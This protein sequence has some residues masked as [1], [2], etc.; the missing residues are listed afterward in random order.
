ML[1]L[2]KCNSDLFHWNDKS[3]SKQTLKVTPEFCI[4]AIRS[5]SFNTLPGDWP[6]GTHSVVQKSSDYW[7]SPNSFEYNCIFGRTITKYYHQLIIQ[8]YHAQLV[9]DQPQIQQHV[10]GNECWKTLYPKIPDHTE[11]YGSCT[12]KERNMGYKILVW[13]DPHHDA[14]EIHSLGEYEYHQSDSYILIPDLHIGGAIQNQY[15]NGII[16]LDNGITLIPTGKK[17]YHINHYLR[18]I[19]TKYAR[20]VGT[21]AIAPILEA[22]IVR[23]ILLEK[24]RIAQEW[25]RGCFLQQ[26]IT[27]LQHWIITTFPS[28]ASRW[29][30]PEAGVIIHPVGDALQ[31]HQCLKVSQY[32]IIL[33]RKIN[34]TCY[35]DFPIQRSGT[36]ETRFLRLSD[37]QMVHL[38]PKINCS[39]R[40]QHTFIRDVHGEFY[41]V[42]SNGSYSLVTPEKTTPFQTTHFTLKPIRGYDYRTI[43]QPPKILE[44]YTALSLFSTMHDALQELKKLQNTHGNGNVLVGIGKALGLAIEGAAKG[45]S[46]VIKAVGSAI[47]DTLDG[48]GDLDEKIVSSLGDAASNVIS[49]TGNAIKDVG[50]GFGS[51]F[52]GFFG[53]IAGLIKWGAILLIML[54]LVYMN[55]GALMRCV[56]RIRRRKEL[57]TTPLTSSPKHSESATSLKETSDPKVDSTTTIAHPTVVTFYPDR[58]HSISTDIQEIKQPIDGKEDGNQNTSKV[59]TIDKLQTDSNK[60]Q[61][62]LRCTAQVTYG[63]NTIQ[64]PAIID[65]GSTSTIIRQDQ[66]HTL[67]S[68]IEVSHLLNSSQKM[69][70]VLGDTFEVYETDI[71]T[72]SIGESTRETTMMVCEYMSHELV[73]GMDT[74]LEIKAVINL[75]HNTF[76]TKDSTNDT[77]LPNC[78]QTTSVDYPRRQFI[79]FCGTEFTK[80]TSRC[81]IALALMFCISLAIVL[82]L[83]V[84][85]FREDASNMRNS[86]YEMHAI[87]NLTRPNSLPYFKT[88]AVLH[89]LPTYVA[90]DF[91]IPPGF[92]SLS[93]KPMRTLLAMESG[94][95]K[96]SLHYEVHCTFNSSIPL[97]EY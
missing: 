7:I 24:Q 54:L 26:E 91:M 89:Q 93:S 33:S 20:Q 42:M 81:F 29:I 11:R 60:F 35:T 2:M 8:A 71:L 46:T 86:T 16:Q 87:W 97:A 44:P 77:S 51:I 78:S 23:N 62:G 64:I 58:P 63:S 43:Y 39:H 72:L 85:H 22:H 15:R 69:S 36:N 12:I 19:I 52:D 88:T 30:H 28:S 38:S 50:S 31:L 74:L 67:S 92:L 94:I 61:V 80:T 32:S 90:I 13:N 37:R 55:R 48:V 59:C 53:G 45:T 17:F 70:T 75:E 79:Q 49:S 34:N 83:S 3:S 21:D 14:H 68:N 27:R 57:E 25:Q 4:N 41:M 66:W 73:I 95:N 10:T 1:F 82:T 56:R 5:K 18:R 65:T 40:P 84:L 96:S 6:A 9:G 76:T 47:H